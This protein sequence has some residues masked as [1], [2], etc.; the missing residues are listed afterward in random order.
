MRTR[1]NGWTIALVGLVLLLLMVPAAWAHR[2]GAREQ[3]PLVIGHR[4][5]AG[6]LPDHTLQGYALA[7][8]LG[9]DYIEPDL[10]ATKDGAADRAPRA[11]HHQHHRRREPPRVRG[12]Q[13]HG[14]RSTASRETGWF[15]SDFTLAEIKT[16][17]AVQPF[18][19]AAAA[20]Q[21]QVRD[22]D[23][24]RGHRAGEAQVAPA[25]PRRSASIPRP[26]TRPTTSDSGCR[27]SAGSSTALAPGRLEPPA[28]AGV[29]PVVRAVE[30]E[31]AQPDDA[32]APRAAGGRQRHQPGRHARPTRRRSTAPTTGP[33]RATRSCRPAPSASSPPTRGSTRSAPTP[34][35]SAPGRCTS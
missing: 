5:A 6:Y 27:S 21:R 7:I 4:G 25:P 31:A 20:V 15:A 24:R 32:G 30:P 17:R 14:D 22:P 9:A 35:A 8:E 34:T 28:R 33:S 12:P 19:R 26:S 29:H 23:V 18:A 1:R 10:V 13:A 11:E 3:S 2:G 16:L